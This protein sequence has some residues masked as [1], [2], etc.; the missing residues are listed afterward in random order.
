MKD[1]NRQLQ[2]VKDSPDVFLRLPMLDLMNLRIVVYA[3]GSFANLKDKGSQIGYVI[4]HVDTSG[5]ISI[6]NFKSHKAYRVV[7][8]AMASETLAFAAAFETDFLLRRQIETVID[9]HVPLLML[10]DSKCLFDVLTSNK[11]TTE[12]RLMLDIFAA[13]QSYSRRE[14]ENIGLIKSEY[15]LA[16]DLTKINGNGAL[17]RAMQTSRVDREIEDFILRGDI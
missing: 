6:L 14:I 5:R 7:K 2:Q 9:R 10:T 13:R 4:S 3:D 1:T 11:N 12:G 16:D 8:S 15:K 17:R